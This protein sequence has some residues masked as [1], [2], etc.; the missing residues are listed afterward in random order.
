MIDL[1]PLIHTVK[2]N[3]IDALIH[4]ASLLGDVQDANL[5]PAFRANCEG[6]IDIFVTVRLPGVEKAV[7]ASGASD[8]GGDRMV[9]RR[10]A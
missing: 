2:V 4:I 6:T 5:T 9:C 3:N 7:C 8:K 10:M 1:L